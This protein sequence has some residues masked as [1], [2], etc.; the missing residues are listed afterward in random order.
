M[1]EDQDTTAYTEDGP[2]RS[3]TVLLDRTD[4][5]RGATETGYADHHFLVPAD[6][7]TLRIYLTYRDAMLFISVLG[8]DDFRGSA[9]RPGLGGR[10]TLEMMISTTEASP[11]CLPGPLPEGQWCLRIDHNANQEDT[12]YHVIAVAFPY[13]STRAI[14]LSPSPEVAAIPPEHRISDAAGWYRGELHAHTFHSDGSSSPAVVA[15]A[16]ESAGLD[17]ISLTDHYTVSGWSAMRHALSNNTLLVRGCEVTSRRGHANLHGLDGPIDVFVDRPGYGMNELADEVHRRGGILCVNHAFS[18]DLGWRV[19]EFDWD[20]ADLIEVLHALEGPNNNNQLALWDHHLRLGRRLIGVAGT[21]SHHP[22][23]GA[24]ALGALTTEVYCDELS[25]SGL[26]AGLRRGMVVA[27]YGPKVGFE[28][29]DGTRTR[30]MWERLSDRGTGIE[31][32]L[33][34]EYGEPLRVFI[35]KN[36]YP[37][38]QRTLDAPGEHTCVVHDSPRASCY[39]RVEVH[40]VLRPEAPEAEGAPDWVLRSRREYRSILAVTNPIFVG[41][42]ED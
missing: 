16:A 28:A 12:E 38:A 30:T 13:S 26:V 33:H 34:L 24:H 25:E 40:R 32:R 29:S 7:E 4:R 19:E 17:Y 6:T 10:V 3:S 11:G 23:E 9:M 27:T 18:G 41:V 8:P 31:L 5:I 42:G 39:Y 36:G 22:T 37:F 2:R 21:D 15:A 35:L 14:E 1:N 20:K